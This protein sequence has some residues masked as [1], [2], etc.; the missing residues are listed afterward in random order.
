[1][2][3]MREQ[4]GRGYKVGCCFECVEFVLVSCVDSTC[5][6]ADVTSSGILCNFLQATLIRRRRV[7]VDQLRYLPTHG[8]VVQELGAV[9]HH[10]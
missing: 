2:F 4:T 9:P 3:F 1:M 8:T 5:G 6:G 7:L 10:M